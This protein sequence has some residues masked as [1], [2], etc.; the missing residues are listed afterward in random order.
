[1][2]PTMLIHT[3]K[4]HNKRIVGTN[5]WNFL[6]VHINLIVLTCWLVLH[7]PVL[8]T[9]I[10]V[11]CLGQTL[12]TIK[13]FASSYCQ[14][15]RASSSSR[16]VFLCHGVLGGVYFAWNCMLNHSLYCSFLS[17]LGFISW[18]Q[19]SKGYRS[20]AYQ[21]IVCWSVWSSMWWIPH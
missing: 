1:M 7:L 6:T 9:V 18:S 17:H 20:Y 5:S 19:P 21:H 3:L 8:S 11:I 4:L 15:L 16:V 14:N 10:L 12:R 2:G 13:G